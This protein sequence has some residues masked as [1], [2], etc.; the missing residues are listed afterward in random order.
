MCERG[1]RCRG[2]A[3]EGQGDVAEGLPL[4]GARGRRAPYTATG[5]G[6]GAASAA[7]ERGTSTNLAAFGVLASCSSM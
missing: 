5:S 2:R 7:R 4:S 3:R 1:A 6:P